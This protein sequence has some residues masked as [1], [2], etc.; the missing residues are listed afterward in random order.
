M[1]GYFFISFIFGLG[2][3]FIVVLEMDVLFPQRRNAKFLDELQKEK[4]L[5]K[6][7]EENIQS[8][9]DIPDEVLKLI[10]KIKNEG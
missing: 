9:E 1:Y 10:E 7:M 4:E 5:E 6:K 3:Y 2:I 8:D